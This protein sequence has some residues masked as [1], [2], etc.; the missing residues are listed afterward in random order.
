MAAASKVSA[1]DSLGDVP[2]P[3]LLLDLDA[4]ERNIQRLQAKVAQAGREVRIRPHAKAFK[5]SALTTAL[6]SSFPRFCA[7]TVREAEVVV[8]GGCTDVL[9]TN[10]VVGVAKLARLAELAKS[11][12]EIGVLVDHPSHVVA[13]ETVA[14]ET[15]VRFSAY[16]EVDAGQ[17]R[18]GITAGSDEAV[19]LAQAIAAAPSLRF[20]GLQCYHG[21]IQHIRSPAEREALVLSGP[22][23]RYDGREGQ[24]R[25]P[26]SVYS[27]RRSVPWSTRARCVLT[28]RRPRRTD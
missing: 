5:S 16:I 18:C 28:G 1:G 26:S 11:G 24:S 22:V 8:A 4:M 19:T 21:A 3:A 13:L 17:N 14:S 15:R 10:Q 2:T 9:V 27:A 23:A 6:L 12:A 25:W 20:G 7:Q